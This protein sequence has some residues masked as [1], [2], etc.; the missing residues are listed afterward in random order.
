MPV[1]KRRFLPICI[2]M[3]TGATAFHFEGTPS[4]LS[5]L[6]KSQRMPVL[7]NNIKIDSLV[8]GDNIFRTHSAGATFLGTTLLLFPQAYMTNNAIAEFAYQ[9]WS[10]FILAV[11]ALTFFA[12][13]L[14]DSA[15]TLLARVLGTMCVAETC[16]YINELVTKRNLLAGG[17]LTATLLSI[18]AFAFLAFGYVASGNMKLKFSR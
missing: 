10:L 9:S 14:E 5:H 13:S 16:L 2:F 12:P 8:K 15:K 1:C 17:L 4:S 18:F 3:L 7:L 11:A 6:R